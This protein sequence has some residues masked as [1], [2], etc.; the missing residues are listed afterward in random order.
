MNIRQQTLLFSR[1]DN[2]LANAS[3][4]GT[5]AIY[6]LSF[7]GAVLTFKLLWIAIPLMIVMGVAAVRLY[8]LQH[9][10]GHNSFFETREQNELAGK[11]L[12][13]F[14]LASFKA[15]RFNHN[16]HH[17]HVG[18]LDERHSN[19]VFTLTAREFEAAGFWR[20]LAYRI[21]RHPLTLFV[22][23]PPVIFF[24]R[25]RLPKNWRT[26]GLGDV[27]LTNLMLAIYL[28][29]IWA[30][31]GANG[32]LVWFLGTWIGMGFGVFV[33]YLQ[34]N[35]EDTYY[36]SNPD[37]D[38]DIAFRKGSSVLAF[39]SF[40][41]LMVANITYHDLHHVN[42]RIPSYRLRECYYA[43]AERP[44]PNHITPRDAIRCVNWKLWDEESEKMVPFP[45]SKLA[46]V[47]GMQPQT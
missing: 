12:S 34:H 29:V 17:A 47:I 8:I 21:Y 26:T 32:L 42:A 20:K 44:Y 28:G 27:V 45:P 4:F 35:F 9:D 24:I 19:E 41:D 5:F 14:T 33:V 46:S 18:D 10:C 40:F 38:A 30:L 6:F 1:R 39:G 16:Q 25:Y 43:V 15:L 7:I 13:I 31:S 2:R 23:G 22:F 37:Y 3:F 11:V 36:E